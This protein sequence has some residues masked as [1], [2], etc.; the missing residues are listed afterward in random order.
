MPT[1]PTVSD[2]LIAFL[3]KERAA[4]HATE[5]PIPAELLKPLVVRDIP[6]DV[7]AWFFDPPTTAPRGSEDVSRHG[8][9]GSEP[10]PEM[11]F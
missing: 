9:V 3:A 11:P 5:R 6:D 1:D 10:D 4:E 2:A 8:V 7:V